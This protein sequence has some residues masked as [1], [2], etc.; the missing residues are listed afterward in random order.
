MFFLVAILV[1]GC[2]S[3]NENPIIEEELGFYS[4]GFSEF[5]TDVY[6][7][8]DDMNQ[9]EYNGVPI[10]IPFHVEGWSEGIRSEFGW[11]LF[12]DGLPQLTQ[13]ETPEGELFRE[14]SY[15]HNFALEYRE[16]FDFY[17]VFSPISGD[18]G[19]T[20]GM[21]SSSIFNPNFMPELIDEPIFALFHTLGGMISAEIIIN[22]ET[23]RGFNYSENV[24]MRP[25]SQEVLDLEEGRLSTEGEVLETELARLPRIVLYPQGH[26]IDIDY[27]GVI[28]SEDGKAQISLVVYG[29]P[30][31]TNR[32]TFF[33]N[34]QPIQINGVD[35]IELQ[36]QEGQMAAID[37]ELELSELEQFN[38][39]YA[40]MMT[41]DEDYRVHGLYKTSSLLLVNE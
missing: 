36:M 1:S 14:M 18:I 35:F 7:E 19:D 22:N 28:L 10:R 11:F 17:V 23:T 26:K 41:I 5:S 3:D 24:Q 34:H 31:V 29:G 38:A 37:I 15:F 40:M 16:R 39:L 25:I 30:E 33:V 21:I 20:V 12:V 13:L 32:I 6:V 2:R 27:E 4:F 8:M 9:F